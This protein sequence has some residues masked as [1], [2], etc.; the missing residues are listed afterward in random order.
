MAAND[1]IVWL[2]EQAGE[3]FLGLPA[4]GTGDRRFCVLG[5]LEG[6]DPSGIG[7]WVDVDFVQELKIP[8]NTAVKTWEVNPRSCLIRWDYITYVQRGE[9]SGTIGF[10]PKESG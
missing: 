2:T 4:T 1:W 10:T 7:V 3:V 8:D 5:R 9:H 6:T